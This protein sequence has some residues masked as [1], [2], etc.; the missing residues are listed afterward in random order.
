MFRAGPVAN[1]KAFC[2][3]RFARWLALGTLTLAAGVASAQEDVNVLCSVN[4]AWCEALSRAFRVDSGIAV[5]I[6]FKDPSD[7]L[8]HVVAERDDPKH[9]VWYASNGESHLL[10]AETGLIDEYQSPLA[11]R[12]RDFAL[13]QGELAKGRAIGT[14]AAVVGIGY[15]SKAL[16]NKQLPEPHCWAD[17]ARPEYRNEL[18][19]ANPSSTRV[20]YTSL[21]TLV[22]LFG[23][24]RAFELMKA[25]HRNAAAYSITAN[26]A[27]RAVARG[28]ATIAV[29]MLHD[30]ASEIVN[31]FPVR[32]V[33]PCEGTGY[34]VGSV[35]VITKAPHPANARKF[36]D[37][38]L[39]PAA[40]R[41]AASARHFEYPANRDAPTPPG[42][43]AIDDVRLIRYDFVKY[44]ASAEHQRL[45]EKWERDVHMLPR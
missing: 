9:D 26:G 23:E 42:V 36:Y 28:E 5:N 45:L 6:T 30:G 35:A 20:G 44:A 41:I 32:L 19:F 17:L 8:A 18:T 12:L 7:A 13:Q 10:A 22:Q 11:P 40:Q 33:V 15:N 21:A 27:M 37:W 2:P 29:T 25:I 14:F 4:V 43:P 38:V 1:L 34:E 31:G 3:R 39:S 24:E 16:V